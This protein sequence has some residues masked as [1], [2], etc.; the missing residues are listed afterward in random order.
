MKNPLFYLLIT[1][2]ALNAPMC[3]FSSPPAK[4]MECRLYGKGTPMSM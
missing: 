2:Y 3:N 1:L 4:Q